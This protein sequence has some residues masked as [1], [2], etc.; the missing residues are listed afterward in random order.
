MA[1]TDPST[2]VELLRSLFASGELVHP[3]LGQEYFTQGETNTAVASFVDLSA[4]IA[5]CCGATPPNAKADQ[6]RDDSLATNSIPEEEFL[7]CRRQ[8]AIEIGG[9]P[10]KGT[11]DRDIYPRKHVVLILCDGMG[12]SCLE[13]AFAADNEASF[14]INNNQSTRLRAVFPST[15]PAALTTLATASWPGRHG[16][17]GWNLRDKKGCD[18]PGHSDSAGPVVQLLVLSDHIKD[19]RSGQLAHKL[20]FDTWDE[21]FVEIPYSRSLLHRTE[22][23]KQQ[24][25]ATRKMMYINAYNGDDYQN[26]SQGATDFSS[27][28]MG[29][30]TNLDGIAASDK[31][32]LFD[33]AKIEETAYD[34][35]GE[36]KGSTDA[37][38]FF[39]NGLNAAL[40]KIAQAE[41]SGEST[42]TYLYTA[43]PD[44]HMHAL[45]TEH[46]EVK[47]V[48]NGFDKE[49][50]RFWALLGDRDALLMRTSFDTDATDIEN[51]EDCRKTA[52]DACICITADHGHVT[53]EPEHMITLPQEILDTLEYANIGVHGKVSQI[54][55]QDFSLPAGFCF[56]L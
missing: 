7:Q 44:K 47:K 24:S 45:G 28:Q 14:L 25:N 27:W 4:S 37:I 31:I 41:R 36:P 22:E 55:R 29:N 33:T 34:T 21:V 39:R 51:K 19:A 48:I 42:F 5:M 26:W 56:Q 3:Y 1:R 54:N 38:N 9:H 43:H 46:E 10:T 50:N 30:D 35:L 6:G 32:S 40:T 23:S 52:I 49:I 15:T 17:P 53:V 11:D 18:F 12:N 20:G 8:L 13:S 2:Q 16:I